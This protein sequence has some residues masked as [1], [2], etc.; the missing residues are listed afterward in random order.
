[1]RIFLRKSLK[2]HCPKRESDPG[3]HAQYSQFASRYLLE[4]RLE[5]KTFGL[6]HSHNDYETRTILL[7]YYK[8][9][10]F[11]FPFFSDSFYDQ[12][13]ITNTSP[14]VLHFYNP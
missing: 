11:K 9:Y 10:M 14:T 1:M 8:V 6:Y 5:S 2:T 7:A 4:M 3:P 12:K 13:R